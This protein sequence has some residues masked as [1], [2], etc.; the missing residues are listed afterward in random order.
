MKFSRETRPSKAA[1][2]ASLY[3]ELTPVGKQS[4]VAAI[5]TT[6]FALLFNGVVSS[7]VQ[8]SQR[9]IAACKR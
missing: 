3:A 8:L 6:V 2:Y 5:R 1:G 7:F 9:L 4:P